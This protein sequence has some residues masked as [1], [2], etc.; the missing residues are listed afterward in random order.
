MEDL[1]I[2]HLAIKLFQAYYDKA[3]GIGGNTIIK[4]NELDPSGQACWI[5]TAQEALMEYERWVV[6]DALGSES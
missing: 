3:C 5:A 6:E 2:K 1:R 4:W